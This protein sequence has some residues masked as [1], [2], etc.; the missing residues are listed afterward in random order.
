[1]KRHLN[2]IALVTVFTSYAAFS[3]NCNL[4][5]KDGSKF[6]STAYSWT[7][8]NLYD[9]KFQKL[10]EDK[11]DELIYSYNKDVQSGKISPASTYPM[12]FSVKKASLSTGGDEYTLTTNI[13]G[14]DYSSYLICKGDTLYSYRN[15]G[16]VELPDGK[17]GSLGFTIQSPSKL[18]MNIKVGDTL[19]SFSDLSFLNPVTTETKTKYIQMEGDYMVTYSLKALETLSF[20][21]N[22]IH[23]VFAKVTAEE[24][25]IISGTKYKAYI[26]ESEKW[27][28]GKMDK[29]VVTAYSDVNEAYKKGIEKLIAKSD[30]MMVK[31]GVT[32][33]LGYMVSY[34]K[35]W[36]VPALG[37]VKTESYDNL[38]GIAGGS[39]TSGVE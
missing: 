12:I 4:A 19:P 2:F 27:H 35:E 24:E 16:V 3:Q 11:K 18:P 13:G 17:G 21:S 32:N 28:K 15:K 23:H 22:T 37:I 33:E 9:P 34:L 7:N 29:S 25:I 6:T 8:P 10:K 39:I 5:Y 26:I 20:S 30:K 1:M 36:Y 38:G 31:K 14:K